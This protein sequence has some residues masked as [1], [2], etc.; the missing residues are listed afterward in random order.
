MVEKKRNNRFSS[1]LDKTSD[2]RKKEKKFEE[3]ELGELNMRFI[4]RTINKFRSY[5]TLYNV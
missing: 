2:V 3:N 5:Q 1:G 4:D